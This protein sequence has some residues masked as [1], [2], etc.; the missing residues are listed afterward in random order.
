MRLGPSITSRA[1]ARVKEL[2]ASLSGKANSP[3]DLLGLEGLHLIGELHKWGH[4]FDTVFLR[5]GS[6]SV[7]ERGWPK[8]LRAAHWAVLSRDVFDSAVTTATPQGIAATWTIVQP[9]PRGPGVTLVLEDVQDPGNFGTLIRSADAFGISVMATPAVASQW[10]PKVVRASAGSVFR[11]AIT[12]API[13]ELLQP[14]RDQGVRIFAAV[15]GFVGEHVMTLPH[16]VLKGRRLDVPGAGGQADLGVPYSPDGYAA[17]LVYDADFVQP[18]AI[19][20]GNEG[21][22]LSE[23]ALSLAD[24]RVQI[25]GSVESL[26][27]GVAGSILMYEEMRQRV[28][29]LWAHKQGLRP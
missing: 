2:R 22:G 14:L 25:P 3:G 18:C 12:R 29:R 26:N 24:E 13:E 20:I 7:L 19:L 27:A 28:L 5:E 23:K 8:D 9:K 11:T 21:A 10:N 17:S 15:A 6:E 4:D 16:G 1:N